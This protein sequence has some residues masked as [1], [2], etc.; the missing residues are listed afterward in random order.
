MSRLSSLPACHFT[1]DAPWF[2]RRC[3]TDVHPSY[4]RSGHAVDAQLQEPARAPGLPENYNGRNGRCRRLRRL[5]RARGDFTGFAVG[6]TEVFEPGRI[7]YCATLDFHHQ[8]PRGQ[9][10]DPDLADQRGYSGREPIA[11]HRHRF[12]LVLQDLEL[13]TSAIDVH[14]EQLY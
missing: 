12:T 11:S 13:Y 2:Y 6:G 1:V 3:A 7:R 4:R 9:N 14:V 5:C 10:A 8:A